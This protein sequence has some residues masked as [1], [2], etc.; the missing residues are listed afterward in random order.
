MQDA[1]T[2]ARNCLECF[3][4]AWLTGDE[5]AI[6][7]ACSPGVRWWTPLSGEADPGPTAAWAALAAVLQTT[8]R[9]IEVTAL[10]ISEDGSRGVLE[11]R[12]EPTAATGSASLITSVVTMSAGKIVEGRTYADPETPPAPTARDS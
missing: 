12:G 6:S 3:T 8:P 2:T 1:R 11:L 9:P 10:A 4:A 7:R 5:D